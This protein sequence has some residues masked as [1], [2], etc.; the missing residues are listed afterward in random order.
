MTTAQDA[1]AEKALADRDKQWRLYRAQKTRELEQLYAD[2][3]YGDRL[4]KFG[5]TLNHFGGEDG[6]K[7][8]GYMEQ[9]GKWLNAAPEPFRFAAL[10]LVCNRIQRI[11]VKA[12]LP[13]FDDALFDEPA[14]VWS[15]CKGVLSV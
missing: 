9:Q 4:R 1:A 12:G 15:R 13:P 8:I 5:A 7:F 10:E 14:D 2:P 6:D 3:E 11:R